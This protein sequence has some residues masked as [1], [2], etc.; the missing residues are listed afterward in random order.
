MFK[1][2]STPKLFRKVPVLALCGA[3]AVALTAT[4]LTK[5]IVAAYKRK[6]A[7]LE[8]IGSK[9]D[10]SNPAE[11]I[12]VATGKTIQVFHPSQITKEPKVVST[13]QVQTTGNSH[14]LWLDSKTLIFA[15]TSSQATS[16]IASNKDGTTDTYSNYPSLLRKLDT[17][18][19]TI[20][21]LIDPDSNTD[22]LSPLFGNIRE[23][24]Q[25]VVN[26]YAQEWEAFDKQKGGKLK[27]GKTPQSTFTIQDI[28][29]DPQNKIYIKVAD[30]WYEYHQDSNTLQNTVALP[31]TLTTSQLS[32]GKLRLKEPD[33]GFFAATMER[34]TLTVS[35]P[36][37]SETDFINVTEGCSS[38]AWLSVI[39]N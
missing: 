23:K 16:A 33:L 8:H 32:S 39:E 1:E 36:E 5:S 9:L 4:G 3:G 22:I 7:A 28:G 6:E 30:T 19:G 2:K 10:S 29:L 18:K 38:A 15:S 11:K 27:I 20:V 24:D 21:T 13:F 35:C 25:I 12:A 17:E 34:N 31:A 37:N 26:S 14:M